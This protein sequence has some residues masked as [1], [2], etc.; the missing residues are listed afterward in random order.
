MLQMINVM[1][2][3]SRR[4]VG[5]G[6]GGRREGRIWMTGGGAIH[7]YLQI[8]QLSESL[9]TF[10]VGTFVRPI[11]RVDSAKARISQQVIYRRSR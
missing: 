8:R 9:F 7:V 5:A 6:S 4:K 1:V 3:A 2:L 10:R 11:A